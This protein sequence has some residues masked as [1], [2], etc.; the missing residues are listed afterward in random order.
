MDLVDMRIVWIV[1]IET[2]FTGT[3]SLRGRLQFLFLPAGSARKPTTARVDL[4]P[5][6][7][8]QM[9]IVLLASGERLSMRNRFG[10]RSHFATGND[11]GNVIRL[12]TSLR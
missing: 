11:F 12:G 9:H 5:L 4:R 8:S 2:I 7:L 1:W 6:W 3:A 10:W